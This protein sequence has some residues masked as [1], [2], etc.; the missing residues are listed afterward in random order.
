MKFLKIFLSVKAGRLNRDRNYLK[1]KEDED[2]D[3][4]KKGKARKFTVG[5][6]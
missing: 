4:K 5:F 3:C 1:I 6:N 2:I